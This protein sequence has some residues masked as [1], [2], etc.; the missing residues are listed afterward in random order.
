MIKLFHIPGEGP[1]FKPSLL[2]RV[3]WYSTDALIVIVILMCISWI[4]GHM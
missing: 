3:L 1:D 2:L 4:A